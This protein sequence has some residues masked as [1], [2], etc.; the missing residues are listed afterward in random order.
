MFALKLGL[1]H[2]I[3]GADVGVVESRSGARLQQKTI[4]SILIAGKL[5]R[6]KFERDAPPE[7]E[8][9]RFVNNSHAAAAEL[10]GNAVMRDGLPNHGLPSDGW[11]DSRKLS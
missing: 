4:Q 1:F 2:R 6:K 7:I 10:A 9:F 3:D 5:R 8:I 11:M